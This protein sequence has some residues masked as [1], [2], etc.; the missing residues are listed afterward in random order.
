MALRKEVFQ[1]KVLQRL[2]PAPLK[3][4]EPSCGVDE[5]AKKPHVNRKRL[6]KDVLQNRTTPDCPAGPVKRI[7]TA[8]PCPPNYIADA[9]KSDTIPLL[10]NAQ[11]AGN[12]AEESV[13]DSNEESDCDNNSSQQ[14][15]RRRRRKMKPTA[16]KD[17]EKEE[18]DFI[19]RLGAVETQEGDGAHHISRNKKRKLKKKRHKEKLLSLG[20]MPR[21]AALE[22]TYQRGGEVDDQMKVAHVSDFLRTTMEIYMSDSALVTKKVPQLSETVEKLLSDLV[23]GSRPPS[24][25]QK[26]HE[27]KVLAQQK[28]GERLARALEDLKDDTLMTEE[29]TAAVVSLFQYWISSILPV[30][31][32]EQSHQR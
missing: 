30:Q 29:E 22:F 21:A 11:S 18:G 12:L 16:H 31:G 15:R 7:Y 8:L 32:E 5:L 10:G 19:N 3:T 26:I 23:S 14:R 13:P 27:L 28:D 4:N 20:L 1:S 17:L 6:Q 24:L 25:L 9:E 2:Y